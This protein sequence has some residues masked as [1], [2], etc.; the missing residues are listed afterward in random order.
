M[1]D[2]NIRGYYYLIIFLELVGLQECEVVHVRA[3]VV[4]SGPISHS[5]AFIVN[6]ITRLSIVLQ[7]NVVLGEHFK[8]MALNRMVGS[9]N[10]AVLIGN[11]VNAM[12]DL[13]P[14]KVV[15]CFMNSYVVLSQPEVQIMIETSLFIDD[16]TFNKIGS[17]ARLIFIKIFLQSIF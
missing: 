10:Y 2:V 1:L 11:D 17:S 14:A 16:C 12:L 13:V 6:E 4:Q 3:S 9:R 8:I 5:E 15:K 7:V